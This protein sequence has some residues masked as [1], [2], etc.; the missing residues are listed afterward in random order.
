M[1]SHERRRTGRF[2]RSSLNPPGLVALLGLAAMTA[3]LVVAAVARTYEPP[4]AAARAASPVASAVPSE[5]T[6]TPVHLAAVGDSITASGGR[7][8]DGIF[9]GNTWLS[10]VVDGVDVR[11]AGGWAQPGAT[12]AAML[13]G[14]E[15]VPDA[16]VL[17]IIAGTN[18][19]G[20]GVTFDITADNL[21]QI[22]DVVDAP[23]VI[24]SSIPPREPAPELADDL[25]ELLRPLAAEQHWEFVDAAAGLRHDD[26]G[27]LPGLT[28]DGIHPVPAGQAVI[29]AAIRDAVLSR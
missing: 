11:W 15:P 24:L 27:W 13:A 21:R 10:H 29:G 8:E 17:V 2:E 19:S 25:N 20:Q 9:N 22:V 6:A 28:V 5:D 16:D 7:L 12:T 26:G 14:V 23:R 3:G 1:S 18:D 4:P